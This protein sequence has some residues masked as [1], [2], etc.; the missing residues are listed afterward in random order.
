M[1]W[2][3]FMR[4]RTCLWATAV[5]LMAPSVSTAF[6]GG[7]PTDGVIVVQSEVPTMQPLPAGSGTLSGFAIDRETGARIAGAR[8]VVRLLGARVGEFSQASTPFGQVLIADKGGEF[9]VP[10]VVFGTYVVEVTMA[11]YADATGFIMDG[12][13][14]TMVVSVAQPSAAEAF[15]LS[16]LGTLEGIVVDQNGQPQADRAVMLIRRNH[17]LGSLTLPE[18][19]KAITDSTGR[20]RFTNVPPN[21]YVVGVDYR[22]T[23]IPVSVSETYR[24]ALQTGEGR[25]MDSRLA[26]S[27][28][29]VPRPPLQGLSLTLGA[30]QFSLEDG[31]RRQRAGAVSPEGKI[32][33]VATTYAPGV[34]SFA[35]ATTYL[36]TSGQ[37]LTGVDIR[38]RTQATVRVSGSLTGPEGT[39]SFVGLSLVPKGADNIDRA[40]FGDA[41]LTVT[42]EKGQF[43]FLG[44]VPGQYTLEGAVL[45]YPAG[46]QVR[47]GSSIPVGPDG[48]ILRKEVQRWAKVAIDA[49]TGDLVGLSVPLAAPFFVSGRV[50]FVMAGDSRPGWPVQAGFRLYLSRRTGQ[51]FSSLTT[52]TKADGTFSFGPAFPDKYELSIGLGPDTKLVS[53]VVNG[54][55]VANQVIDL[56]SDLKDV[57]I[58]FTN[59]R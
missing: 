46:G 52:S 56:N 57:V 7:W 44:V 11:G 58:T 18:R 21:E 29:P 8:V 20:Y 30:F 38:I 17:G 25:R 9:I 50:V 31:A 24:R 40:S 28:A 48:I 14:R 19:A 6:Q 55:D 23:T 12:S 47:P 53:I 36:L 32:M 49:S 4:A 51:Q 10:K 5:L 34:T 27:N 3:P 35:E 16:R 15:P 22:S 37:N 33:G 41:A 59:I 2:P 39:T 42:D 13:R 1:L 45:A 26:E 54:R 43:S